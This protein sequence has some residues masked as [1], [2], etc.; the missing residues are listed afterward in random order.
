MDPALQEMLTTE[1]GLSAEDVKDCAAL[2]QDSGQGLDRLLV[3]K[4][5]LTEHQVL[6]ILGRYLA[7]PFRQ[8][9]R[10]ADVPKTFVDRVPV[11]FAR[12][13]NLVGIDESNGTVQVATCA[14]FDLHPLDD[15][16]TMLGKE[17]DVVLAPKAEITALINRAYKTKAD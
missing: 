5:Y 9:L 7:Y 3:S 16:A 14:P 12:T 10:E 15:V 6:K 17:A 2:A 8:D 4:G 1:G 11:H 13:F